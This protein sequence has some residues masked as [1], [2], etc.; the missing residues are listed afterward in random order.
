MYT[1]PVV[2]GQVQ[3]CNDPDWSVFWA[4]TK[5]KKNPPNNKLYAGKHVGEDWDAT[6]NTETIGYIVI[7]AGEGLINNV[8]FVAGVGPRIVKGYDNSSNGYLYTFNS[9]PTAS[10]AIL[11]VA[12]MSNDGGW[13]VLLGLNPLT[14]TS[15]R[16]IYDEDVIKDA[17]RKHPR[18]KVAY[19]VFGTQ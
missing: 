5:N 16:L 1:D 4:S 10:T 14:P 12:G 18:E 11:S 7:E 2:V 17:E 6:R 19:I 15:I 3:T 9:L 13:P 8:P